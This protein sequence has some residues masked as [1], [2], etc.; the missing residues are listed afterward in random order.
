[1]SRLPI[2]AFLDAAEA[3]APLLAFLERT[4]AFQLTVTHDSAR[5]A[6]LDG[7]R[8][9]L[10]DAR[11][12][13]LDTEEARA[14]ADFVRRG[15]GLVTIGDTL[16]AWSGNPEVRE[17]HGWALGDLTDPTELVVRTTPGNPLIERLDP[18][19][20]VRDR[21]RLSDGLPTGA[22][23]LLRVPWR[24][25]DRV[26]AFVRLAAAGRFA[27]LGLGHL[28][29]TFGHPVFGQLVNR[30][31]RNA[32]GL[33]G[34][35]SLGVGLIGY[36]AVAKDHAR[37]ITEVAGLK[38]R[39]VADLAAAR[40]TAA[41]ADFGVAVHARTEDLLADPDIE[42]AV[43]GTPPSTHAEV[44]LEALAAGKH[45]VCEKPFALRVADVDRMLEAAAGAGK[46]LTVYQ[47]RRWDPD[48]VALREAVSRKAVGEP[49]H[50]ESFIGGFGHPCSFWHTHE[51]VSGG[52]IF[53][54]GS[55]Y[56]DW[57]LQLFPGEVDTVSAVAHNL[58]WHD[59][60]NAD[61]VSVDVRFRDGRQ[62]TFIH[63]DV[64]A[65]LKPKWYLL[66]TAGA[67][68]ADWRRESVKTRSETGDLIEERLAP[69]DSPAIVRIFRPDG[70]GGAHEETLSLPQRVINGFYRNLADHLLE[71]EPPAV[72]A[73]EARQNIA[74][75]EAAARSIAQGGRAVEVRA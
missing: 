68:V 61:H 31:L 56:F 21:L 67:I 37:Q 75:M 50:L 23:E 6:D 72:P 2:L 57:M 28:P 46:L 9:V 40:R 5:L 52:T 45:V 16:A 3:A 60:T 44:V 26:L 11:R 48:F 66:G 39:V 51:P 70:S 32:A 4:G 1:M 25:Q 62:A 17:L 7:F 12:G 42:V 34:Q 35:R 14:L 47:S 18:E 59:V 36:G 49:F 27:A 65:A 13:P 63:S 29:E 74:V 73:R 58:V 55:H 69:A 53:D 71:G 30:L 24:Y 41:A 38:L 15:G 54:W 10:A 19:F 20:H 8:A 33:D 64:A 43:V 22:V